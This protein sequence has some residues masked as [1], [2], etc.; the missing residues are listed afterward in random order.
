VNSEY[1][2]KDIQ[3]PSGSGVSEYAVL[4]TDNWWGTTDDLSIRARTRKNFEC[5]PIPVEKKIQW[6]P[7]SS[8]PH[9]AWEP[10]GEV[11]DPP[12]GA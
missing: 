10:L 2:S 11:P 4:A 3:A 1:L 12:P 7:F 6:N 8:A 5:C 9:T